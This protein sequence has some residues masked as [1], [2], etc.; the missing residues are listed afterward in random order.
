MQQVG[1]SLGIS[2]D[3][4]MSDP[5]SLRG[6][7]FQHKSE[8]LRVIGPSVSS[9]VRVLCFAS[10]LPWCAESSGA[11]VVNLRPFLNPAA[12]QALSNVTPC[13]RDCILRHWYGLYWTG[14]LD[15]V[16]PPYDSHKSSPTP[17]IPD[18]AVVFSSRKKARKALRVAAKASKAAFS[19][20]CKA[21]AVS[22]PGEH[23]SASSNVASV[24]QRYTIDDIE[25]TLANDTG[26]DT[27]T[28]SNAA[29]SFDSTSSYRPAH[30]DGSA[31]AEEVYVDE[32]DDDSTAATVY[33]SHAN[34]DRTDEILDEA[35]GAYIA[36]TA[37][38]AICKHVFLFSTQQ[39]N[40]IVRKVS[41]KDD[42]ND[43]S[44]L[45]VHLTEVNSGYDASIFR[46]TMSY[47]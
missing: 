42:G 46:S 2:N 4:F 40:W 29:R 21:S 35:V 44:P 1:I 17:T 24:L 43:S 18:E 45:V 27:T 6:G 7:Y 39:A 30:E 25:S 3:T 47:Y 16:H 28:S 31:A 36:T 5:D 41:P 37:I 32:R 33:M 11:D 15:Y 13:Q 19:A 12:E 9:G 23:S 20:A 26:L 34:F 38:T 14:A 22:Q 10:F 8:V